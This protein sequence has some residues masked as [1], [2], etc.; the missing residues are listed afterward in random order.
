MEEKKI[1]EAKEVFSRNNTQQILKSK[2]GDF[3]KK[4]Y[5]YTTVDKLMAILKGDKNG[6]CFL[7]CRSIAAMNDESEKKWHKEKSK[8]IHSFCVCYA[9]HEKIPLWYLYS[10]ICGNGARIGFPPGKMLALLRSIDTIYPVIGGQIDYATPLKKEEDFSLDCGWVFYLMDGNNRIL[11]RR[12]SYAVIPITQSVLKKNYFIKDYPWEYE[13]EFRLVIC[14]KTNVDYE[15]IA[16]PLPKKL[17]PHLEIM[18]APERHFTETEKKK[19]TSLGV[20]F[21]KI[22]K[23]DLGICMDLLKR[24]KMDIAAQ[25]DKWCSEEECGNV[26][27]YVRMKNKCGKQNGGK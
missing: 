12:K 17:V 9:N 3:D 15:A 25:I 7:F 27:A 16:I 1:W 22:K 21:N 2:A 14:N 10:G 8:K 23:S 18:S 4:F 11:Y 6:D 24:N 13:Q 19:L 20:S 26:C 5:H